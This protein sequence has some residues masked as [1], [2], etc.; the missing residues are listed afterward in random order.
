MTNYLLTGGG[1]A[2]HVNPLLSLADYISENEP[3]AKIFAL[4]TKEG[5][6][7]DLVPARGYEL[8][9]IA[10]LPFPRK[11]TPSAFVFPAAFMKAV[12][13]VRD[14]IRRN[15][16]DIV[17]GFGGYASA[18]AY[19]AARLEKTKLVIHEANALPGMAN[20]IGAKFANAVAVAFIDTPLPNASYQG[21][22]LR[23][24][25]EAV[26]K[27]RDTVGARKHFGLDEDMST[28]LVTGGSLGARSINQTIEESRDLLAAA[29][30]QVLHIVGGKSDLEPLKQKSYL[31]IKYCDRMDL[32]LSAADFAVSRAGAATVSEL[33]ALGVPALYIP[34]GVGN[35]E[36]RHNIK[37][38]LEAEA[39]ISCKDSEFSREFV[40]QTLVPLLS[41]AKRLSLMSAAARKLAISDGTANLYRLVQGVLSN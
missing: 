37:N 14:I 32:A 7:K 9:T 24:E 28:L 16:I 35:G 21:M 26:I 25:I 41:S 20:K 1:T 19:L 5:L 3:T 4:G 33:T 15:R 8:L 30:V 13:Q 27:Q 12:N 22:P 18:P 34:Y 31:R 17:V 6:E 11:I 10:K 38:V 36:Q 39:A 23:K 2:G 29:G 40:A